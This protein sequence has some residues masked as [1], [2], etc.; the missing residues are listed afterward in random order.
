MACATCPVSLQC[1]GGYLPLD[2][3][4]ICYAC[5]CLVLF[6][7]HWNVMQKH[8]CSN[9]AQLERALTNARPFASVTIDKTPLHE[10]HEYSIACDECRAR[11]HRVAEDHL[12]EEH[13][14]Y[15][16]HM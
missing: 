8:H 5:R 7:E 13:D 9:L 1:F 14:Y 3:L 10:I 12:E 6:D 2:D 11:G 15:R 16:R 4:G